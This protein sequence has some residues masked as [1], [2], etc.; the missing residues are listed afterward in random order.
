MTSENSGNLSRRDLIEG[1]AAGTAVMAM[2]PFD[3]LAQTYPPGIEFP[4]NLYRITDPY[5]RS[6]N[7]KLIRI[8]D[9]FNALAKQYGEQPGFA[10]L[11]QTETVLQKRDAALKE[12]D[13]QMIPH[14]AGLV[15]QIIEK[16][17][18]PTKREGTGIEVASD[19]FYQAYA[20][21]K[22]DI[23]QIESFMFFDYRS[24]PRP[25]GYRSDIRFKLKS[26][27]FWTQRKK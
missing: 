8:F 10:K 15:K 17:P 25:G 6:N 2:F 9:E 11:P 4:T 20:R 18:D 12:L 7:G 16:Q 1:V 3:S 21:A 13:L 26:D 23:S 24:K 19:S 22:G 14:L 5:L 27:V